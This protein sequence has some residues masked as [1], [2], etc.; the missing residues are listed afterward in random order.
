VSDA[1]LLH[2]G[3]VPVLDRL[4]ARPPVHAQHRALLELLWVLEHTVALGPELDRLLDDIVAGPLVLAAELP[5]PA[6]AERLP[7]S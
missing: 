4:R 2:V 6:D 7:P 3:E 1:L 5:A